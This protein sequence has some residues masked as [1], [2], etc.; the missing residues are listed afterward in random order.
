M[1]PVRALPTVIGPTENALRALL[2]K[3]LSMTRIKTYPAWV[4]LNAACNRDAS[5]EM[6]L[7]PIADALKVGL[8][9]VEGVLVDLG[10][11]GLVADDGTVSAMGRAELS[12]ARAAVS[13]A[14]DR[15]V[16][17]IG[18]EEQAIARDVLDHIRRKADELL[19]AAP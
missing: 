18:A 14:T 9:E 6:W 10:F 7:L 11:A 4:V 8:P 15:L 16:D 19:L 17:G 3:I 13:A 1:P 2:V 5:R 12:A